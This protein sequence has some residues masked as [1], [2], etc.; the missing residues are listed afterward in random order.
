MRLVFSMFLA[1]LLGSIPTG[2][3]LAMY[4]TKTDLRY[5]GSGNV[6]A[7]NVLRAAGKLAALVTLIID[8]MKGYL[9][10]TLMADMLYNF[11]MGTNFHHFQALL[12]LSVV[13]GHN[14]PVFLN[15][16]GGKGVATSAG[17]LLGLC[18]GA[19]MLGAVV[20]VAV[21]AFS[22]IVSLSSIIGAVTIA[23]AAYFFDYSVTVRFI[24]V[25]L[26]GLTI[27]RHSPNIQRLLR[28][29]EKKIGVK[30]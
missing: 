10:V 4:K 1:Y 16:K 6:G 30:K 15:F 18:P 5:F 21:F 2:Y 22:K 14:W 26:S 27:L 3:L 7:T 24:T 23:A 29:Q 17:V 8:I 25:A 12:S 13:T 19:V 11:R 9:A 20:W 28:N